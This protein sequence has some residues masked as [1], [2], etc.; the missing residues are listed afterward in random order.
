MTPSASARTRWTEWTT[1]SI[2]RIT[3]TRPHHLRHTWRPRTHA[4]RAAHVFCLPTA[5]PAD[6]QAHVLQKHLRQRG[7][8]QLAVCIGAVTRGGSES[9]NER[10]FRWCNFDI[11]FHWRSPF[12]FDDRNVLES[13]AIGQKAM[14]AIS[15]I[16]TSAIES[17]RILPGAPAVAA[18]TDF[19][20]KKQNFWLRL[21]SRFSKSSTNDK[22]HRLTRCKKFRSIQ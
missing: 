20:V 18:S 16:Q 4:R 22:F 15:V 10:R 2:E 21:N 19:N 8:V 9:S 7:D 14:R 13:R 3:I 12:F 11:Y 17:L 6:H 1:T 5:R